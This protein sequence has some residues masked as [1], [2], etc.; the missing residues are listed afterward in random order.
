[1]EDVRRRCPRKVFR[2]R[3]CLAEALRELLYKRTSSGYKKKIA[4]QP[5][6]VSE[7]SANASTQKK[8]R[9]LPSQFIYKPRLRTRTT[10][11]HIP[12]LSPDLL[13]LLQPCA[14][15]RLFITG[16]GAK[17]HS[18]ILSPG[19]PSFRQVHAAEPPNIQI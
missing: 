2:T 16:T 5:T 15:F 9:K 10:P 17:I 19:R 12:S 18:L 3:R 4:Q 8:K 14:L 6:A 1:M 7:T 13:L 11:Q